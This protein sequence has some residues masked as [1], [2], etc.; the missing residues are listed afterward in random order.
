MRSVAAM[1]LA[2]LPALAAAQSPG[3]PATADHVAIYVADADASAAFYRDAFAMAEMPTKLPNTHWLAMGN[4][5]ALHIIGGRKG[6]IALPL[7]D[8]L[9][10]MTATLETT[11]AYLDAHKIAWRNVAGEH[12]IQT[13]FDGVRQIFIRDPDGYWIELSDRRGTPN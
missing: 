9:A 12:A 13:R 6:A 2:A 3:P 10:L 8:H 4:G 11:I 1:I 5:M 7:F